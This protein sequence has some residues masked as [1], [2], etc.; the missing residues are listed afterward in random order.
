MSH[1]I[2][3][4]ILVALAILL[5]GCSRNP[6]IVKRKYLENGDKY[7]K[8][9]KYK[10]ASIMYRNAVKIDP[11]YGDAY[12]KLGESELRRGD[13]RQA[14]RA[15]RRA[16]E[17]LPNSETA[18]GELADIYLAAYSLQ[19]NKQDR[20]LL[21]E[22]K[23][24]YSMLLK[25]NPNSFDGHRLEGFYLVTQNDMSGAI[26]AFRKAQATRPDSPEVRFAL[27]QVLTTAGQAEEAE[28][29]ALD[30]VNS[31]PQYVPA[32]DFL[33]VHYLKANRT[34]E[35][36]QILKK[37][38]E[39]H[40]ATG[41]I[42]TQLAGFY[43]AL[44]RRAEGD[45]LIDQM[46]AREKTIPNARFEAGDFYSRVRDYDRALKIFEQGAKADPAKATR[47]HLR[48]SMVYVSQ[49]RLQDALKVVESTLADSP[50]DN[51]ALSM[52]AALELQLGDRKQSQAAIND[53]QTLIGRTPGNPVLRYNLARAYHLRGEIEAA[54]VQ[55]SEALKLRPDFMAALLGLGQVSLYRKDWGKAIEC[56]DQAIRLN[57]NSIPAQM[58]KVSALINSRNLLQA[59]VD[60]TTFLRGHPDSPDL[61]FQV[62]LIDLLEKKYAVAESTFR[63]LRTLYPKD[64]RL[65]Y[66]IA[67]VNIASGRSGE[68]LA[69]LQNELK[70]APDRLDL[71]LAIG[72]V[73][74]KTGDL[75]IA[76]REY[77][78]L[79]Q[80]DPKN[81]ELY[82]RLGETLRRVGRTQE[83]LDVLRKGRALDPNN[84]MA[85]LQLALTLDAAGMQRES[86]PLY[87]AVVKNQ[88]DNAIALNN[89]AFMMAEE[90]RDL[91]QALTYAQRARQQLPNNADVTDT[92]GWI[93]IRKNLNDN[94]V[95]LYRELTSKV[96]TNPIYQYHLGM[97]L[98]QKGDKAGA[99]RCLQTALTLRPSRDDETKIKELLA[100]LG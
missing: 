5:G 91:D 24:L 3:L 86:L 6:D 13:A 47:Y 21:L 30:I 4:P 22:V 35:A 55:Y 85:T 31:K 53:L 42:Y 79:L 27:A 73:A 84:A 97:A 7:Y 82:M 28:K 80:R 68:A 10:E 69:F 65:A 96:P 70:S 15:L 72:N 45:K 52:R 43:Y 74:M 89:L 29:T 57:Q 71:H 78:L 76:E 25:R 56:A 16:V 95:A 93:Y 41:S 99:R 87:E 54:R 32:Y 9:G 98:A 49:G 12:L 40:P 37:K 81:V 36:E 17:L 94:A 64:L 23:D 50:N 75:D 39:A 34:A 46:I 51:D 90:G 100:K 2:L 48:S 19:R 14:V 60:A 1:R 92:L 62:A 26:A 83:A 77:R 33:F 20:G 88:P 67:E 44:Q 61:Q 63:Q 59:R 18:A 58:I 8:Q 66:A 11:K 38:L